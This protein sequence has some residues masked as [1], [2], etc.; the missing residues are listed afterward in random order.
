MRETKGRNGGDSAQPLDAQVTRDPADPMRILERL[1]ES[2]QHTHLEHGVRPQG[3]PGTVTGTGLAGRAG[4]H[5]VGIAG[6]TAVGATGGTRAGR[7]PAAVA[8]TL[9]RT[10]TAVDS[11]IVSVLAHAESPADRQAARLELALLVRLRKALQGQAAQGT[12]DAVLADSLVEFA[13]TVQ[14][15]LADLDAGGARQVRRWLDFDRELVAELTALGGQGTA[16]KP[17]LQKARSLVENDHSEH[18][19]PAS[20]DAVAIFGKVA[21]DLDKRSP[22]G[23]ASLLDEMTKP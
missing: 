15:V 3:R 16:L 19:Q 8:A 9:G 17:L 1:A 14:A 11:R 2:M 20:R 21:G 4:R 23:G 22:R 18:V 6:R 7:A 10:L 5:T 13:E 12:E